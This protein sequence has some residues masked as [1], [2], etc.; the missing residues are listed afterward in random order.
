MLPTGIKPGDINSTLYQLSYT[1]PQ[2]RYCSRG[3]G[4]SQR[5]GGPAQSESLAKLNSITHVWSEEQG[6]PLRDRRLKNYYPPPLPRCSFRATQQYLR[7]TGVQS[8]WARFSGAIG[9]LYTSPLPLQRYNQAASGKPRV[10]DRHEA[11]MYTP[12]HNSLL[13]D[14][15]ADGFTHKCLYII[16]R[17][18]RFKSENV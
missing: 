16:E 15:A 13:P 3:N 4:I 5:S 2:T 7:M 8:Q 9:P 18:I 6:K 14:I 1:G 11:G 17:V 10:S 12:S